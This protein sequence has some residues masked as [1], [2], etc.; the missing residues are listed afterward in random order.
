MADERI[1]AS[2]EKLRVLDGLSI[3]G[4]PSDRI[5]LS[6]AHSTE[7][8]D[9]AISAIRWIEPRRYKVYGLGK[10]S[11]ISRCPFVEIR[12]VP[13]IRERIYRLTKNIIGESLE[14]LVSGTC[15]SK[16]IVH[17]PLGIHQTFSIS[18][19]NYGDAAVLADRLR[20]RWSQVE[21]KLVSR[22]I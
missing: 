13:Y 5:A 19:F 4:I 15:V 8:I 3:E 17:E 20:A 21:L 12:F 10:K 2:R 16:A 7:R 18:E 11:W 9:V 6:L 22:E 1:R 14:I